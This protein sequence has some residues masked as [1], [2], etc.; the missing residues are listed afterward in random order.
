MEYKLDFYQDVSNYQTILTSF[1]SGEK[2][3]DKFFNS[4]VDD[5]NEIC[6][7]FIF[8][9]DDKCIGCCSLQNDTC[10]IA[11]SYRKQ[12]NVKVKNLHEYPAITLTYFGINQQYQHHGYG[13]EMMF[14]LFQKLYDARNS[15]GA[16]LILD[17]ESLNDVVPF[18]ESFG[19][20][21]INKPNFEPTTFLGITVADMETFINEYKR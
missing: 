13:T 1:C 8:H 20:Q 10:Q 9:E 16:Y 14:A 18:Y 3:V 6:N 4:K 17:V 12:H 15:L 7:V 11:N 2:S 19:F 5:L 21:Q